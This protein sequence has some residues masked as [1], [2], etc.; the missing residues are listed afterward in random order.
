MSAPTWIGVAILGSF[1]SLARFLVDGA[2]SARSP[3]SFPLGTLAVN[4]SGAFILGLLTGLALSGEALTLAGSAT[5][6][7]YTTFSTWMLE[8]HRLG[9][10]GQMFAGAL[11]VLISVLIG[12]GAALLGR[13]LGG[14]L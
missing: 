5:I 14:A 9:E 2:V 1:G 3:S 4:A 8:T 6:G 10:D 11:N 13:S 12:L 7:S